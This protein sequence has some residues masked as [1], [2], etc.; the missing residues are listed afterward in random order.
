MDAECTFS[1]CLIYYAVVILT[2]TS[3]SVWSMSNCSPRDSRGYGCHSN[4]NLM[5]WWQI[6]F[7]F[8]RLI[9]WYK[10]HIPRIHII[11]KTLANLVELLNVW[12]K[13]VYHVYYYIALLHC[14]ILL[15]IPITDILQTHTDSDSD[16]CV[17]NE[18]S[19]W[20]RSSD[21]ALL[22]HLCSALPISTWSGCDLLPCLSECSP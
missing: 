6:C 10:V 4:A 21:L 22:S 18:M 5:Q 19:A 13:Y 11:K 1:L 15:Y 8:K 17:K 3:E 14:L 16:S 20:K 2:I 12:N 7:P 9:Y